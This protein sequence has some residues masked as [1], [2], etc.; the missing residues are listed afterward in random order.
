MGLGD[1]VVLNFQVAFYPTRSHR[2]LMK[3]APFE[4]SQS[5]FWNAAIFVKIQYDQK[6]KERIVAQALK[7]NFEILD[8]VSIRHH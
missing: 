7:F 8:L 3:F 5:L 4:R 6:M 1:L 2:I